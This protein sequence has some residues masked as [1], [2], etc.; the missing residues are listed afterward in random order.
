MSKGIR[1]PV[2]KRSIEK[3]KKIIDT[4]TKIFND[5]GYLNTTTAEIAKEAGL[6]TGSVYAYFKDKK[7]IF[8]EVLKLYSNSIYNNT[9][10]NLN[11]IK[12]KNDL[13]S[14]VDVIVNSVLEN[15]KFSPRFHQEIAMLACTDTY[16]KNC[17]NEHQKIQIDKYME[18]LS[19]YTSSFSNIKEKLFLVYALIEGMCHEVLY[20]KDSNFNKDILVIECKKFVIKMLK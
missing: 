16:I 8:V 11:K 20:N 6:A 5:K 12:N 18:K 4:A 17:Y 13:I 19:E 7:D 9:I 14:L 3:R 1:I 10:K 2:Q 15:H